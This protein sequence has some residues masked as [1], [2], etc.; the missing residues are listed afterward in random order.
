[1]AIENYSIELEAELSKFLSDLA[2]AREAVQGLTDISEQAA[3]NIE[4]SFS[5]INIE[6]NLQSNEINKFSDS[7]DKASDSSENFSESGKKASSTFKEIISS[8]TGLDTSSQG[9]LN[10]S[11]I[12]GI[13]VKTVAASAGTFVTLKLV[14][15][16]IEGV[17]T[18]TNAEA[19]RGVG[20]FARGILQVAGGASRAAAQL[21]LLP[22]PLAA[23]A[24][25]LD[26]TAQGLNRA[27]G[28]FVAMSKQSEEVVNFGK[29]FVSQFDKVE[30]SIKTLALRIPGLSGII[31]S[32]GIQTRGSS[33]NIAGLGDEIG[34]GEKI[35]NAAKST[36]DSFG[37]RIKKTGS[38]V[39][40]AKTNINETTEALGKIKAGAAGAIPGLGGLAAKSIDLSLGA[41]AA[42]IGLSGIAPEAA[43]A[44]SVISGGL[45]AAVIGINAALGIFANLL[46][47]ISDILLNFTI[48]NSKAAS[49]VQLLQSRLEVALDVANKATNNATGTFSQFQGIIND[50]SG[51]LGV[52]LKDVT[53]ITSG[54]VSLQPEIGL[55]TDQIKELTLIT[56]AAGQKFDDQPRA[57]RATQNAM[58]GLTQSIRLL[59]GA[60]VDQQSTQEEINR[61]LDQGGERAEKFLQLTSKQQEAQ[62]RFNIISKAAIPILGAVEHSQD[63]LNIVTSKLS[64]SIKNLQVRFGEFSSPAIVSIVQFFNSLVQSISNLPTPIIKSI[65]ET[66]SFVAIITAAIG[67]FISLAFVIGLVTNGFTILNKVLSGQV[68]IL[69]SVPNLLSQAF[70]SL[71]G[72]NVQVDSATSLFKAFGFTIV[73]QVKNALDALGSYLLEITTARN[74]TSLFGTT[75]SSL[76]SPFSRFIKD[77]GSI[78]LA[79]KDAVFGVTTYSTALKTAN[80]T[81]TVFALRNALNISRFSKFITIAGIVVAVLVTLEEKY[82]FFSAAIDIVNRNLFEFESIIEALTSV[83]SFFSKLIA[84]SVVGAVGLL[85]SAALGV[86][87]TLE[88]LIRAFRFVVD[89]FNTLTLNIFR[90]QKAID[91][92]INSEN[93]LSEVQNKLVKEV[94]GTG[95]QFIDLVQRIGE[96]DESTSKLSGKFGDLLENVK[97]AVTGSSKATR[98]FAEQ[99]IKAFEDISKAVTESVDRVISEK[100]RETESLLNQ[101]E[102]QVL[103]EEVKNKKIRDLTIELAN[104]IVQKETEKSQ[105]LLENVRSTEDERIN[106]LRS[107]QN[108]IKTL[109]DERLKNIQNIK[110]ETLQ[111]EIEIKNNLIGVLNTQLGNLRTF[112]QQRRKIAADA[113]QKIR[114]IEQN[115]ADQITDIRINIREGEK[116]N[117]IV[118]AEIDKNLAEAR[119]ANAEGRFKDAEKITQRIIGLNSQ[120][121]ETEKTSASEVADVQIGVLQ[122]VGEIQVQTQRGIQDSSTASAKSAEEAARNITQQ[123]E[124]LQDNVLQ[125]QQQLAQTRVE[126]KTKFTPDLSEVTSAINRLKS[127]VITIPAQVKVSTADIPGGSIHPLNEAAATINKVISPGP[128]FSQVN[129]KGIDQIA[130]RI[131]SAFREGVDSGTRHITGRRIPLNLSLDEVQV[132]PEGLSFS[133]VGQRIGELTSSGLASSITASKF[134]DS[135][136]QLQTTLALDMERAMKNA[137]NV[138]G[139]ANG[140]RKSF[141]GVF[142]EGAKAARESFQEGL[143]NIEQDIRQVINRAQALKEIR[144]NLRDN[145]IVRDIPVQFVDSEGNPTSINKLFERQRQQFLGKPIPIELSADEIDIEGG[146]VHKLTDAA[147]V[148]QEIIAPESIQSDIA[149]MTKEAQN[150]FENFADSA[151]EINTFVKANIQQSEL[152]NLV[153]QV[154]NVFRRNDF[155]VNLTADQIDIKGASPH[156]FNEVPKV[157]SNLFQPDPLD[158]SGIVGQ[159]NVQRGLQIPGVSPVL[160]PA[161]AA[162]QAQRGGTIPNQTIRVDVNLNE[163]KFS[164]DTAN[165]ESANSLIGLAKEL[166]LMNKTQGDYVSP[167]R[168]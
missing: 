102:T 41:K 14:R 49:T 44:A 80:E 73:A 79:F 26:L 96:T 17:T 47:K 142:F 63:N 72:V 105:I 8:T 87:F 107:S 51:T 69:K 148:L 31:K 112:A 62:A 124:N 18:A 5:N 153:N 150:M 122:K 125:L 89:S 28:G 151:S 168:Q 43:A 135:L 101:I 86:A 38:T 110:A 99:T 154:K 9:F 143:A 90:S 131:S 45:L 76:F 75:V 103:D 134:Q 133:E 149:L 71:S 94:R 19:L 10:F 152:N 119:R 48:E 37:E 39:R 34:K 27:A 145:P 147:D 91:G 74:V 82:K 67:K 144:D 25:R 155:K 129:F 11:R 138:A 52:A 132:G 35:A 109:D 137:V 36:F 56:A 33:I 161:A 65:A 166:E 159:L 70:S 81:Q 53:N 120:I 20:R 22:K 40:N 2:R 57:L 146:S 141:S 167:F 6:E 93:F 54:L 32:F 157:L 165:Q 66:I 100:Q 114:D 21:G 130:P 55:T 128:V 164:V 58:L 4:K 42:S 7:L 60:N 3:S 59:I 97:G 46:S 64:S 115:I 111:A 84:V 78:S 95:S 98:V 12:F 16:F 106:V 108:F 118:L 30:N 136:K 50:V 127:T 116:K 139:R 123:L 126:I 117:A 160:S 140:V 113:A 156:T 85:E 92:L 29:R 88:K 104:F 158:L 13:F 61:I 83:L 15:N 77:L 163:K 68:G 121:V 1:M 162:L 23:L 24:R